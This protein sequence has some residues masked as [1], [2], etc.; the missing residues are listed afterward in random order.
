[1]KTNR[2]LSL[3]A[4]LA[5][6]ACLA[7]NAALP[8]CAAENFL[9]ADTTAALSYTTF[10]G[11]TPIPGLSLNLPAASTAY[12]TAVVTLSMPNLYLNQPTSKT[13]MSATLQL[14]APFAPQGLVAAVGNI[15]C[16]TSGISTSG[17]K[18]ITIVVAIPLGSAGQ[19]VTAEWASNGSSTVNTNTFASL[20]AVLVMRQ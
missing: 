16:D 17:T 15:G 2:R 18:P 11:T 14:I 3:S 20:S 5:M 19:P 7:L 13:P 10:V 8:L 9:Y 1:M 4:P 12:N 6:L